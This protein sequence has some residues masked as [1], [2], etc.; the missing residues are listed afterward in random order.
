MRQL[1]VIT[2]QDH[3]MSV[4]DINQIDQG[5]SACADDGSL[6]AQ[7]P[8]DVVAFFYTGNSTM[9]LPEV[10]SFPS[11]GSPSVRFVDADTPLSV[12]TTEAPYRVIALYPK[13]REVLEKWHTPEH[14]DM[15]L[16]P[17]T[18]DQF[19]TVISNAKDMKVD[20]NTFVGN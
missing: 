5:M 10:G 2:T 7:W 18:Q 3:V 15:I 12:V 4:I 1:L 9:H 16:D 14:V 8:T 19:I 13:K 11:S 20:S 6:A 17:N